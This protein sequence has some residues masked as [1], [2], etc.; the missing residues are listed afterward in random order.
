MKKL[1]IVFLFLA[2]ISFGQELGILLKNTSETE[3]FL[4][5]LSLRY[6]YIDDTTIEA[7]ISKEYK[8]IFKF[9]HDY[10]YHEEFQTTDL[11]YDLDSIKYLLDKESSLLEDNIYYYDVGEYRF[12][13]IIKIYDDHYS[14]IKT[15]KKN[16]FNKSTRRGRKQ[17]SH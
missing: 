1:F 10:C 15:I 8:F 7:T 16:V 17:R 3:G 6:Q 4:E 5:K 13:Y 12:F 11:S 2:N 14:V 9:T